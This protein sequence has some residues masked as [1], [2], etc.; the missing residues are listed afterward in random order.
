MSPSDDLEWN[1]ACK[2]WKNQAPVA[3]GFETQSCVNVV[4]V[5]PMIL[6]FLS[7]I[8]PMCI[9]IVMK[10]YISRMKCNISPAWLSRSFS[11]FIGKTEEQSGN[12]GPYLFRRLQ[13]WWNNSKASLQNYKSY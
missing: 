9:G 11:K 2:V 8:F 6:F 10:S 12:S 5:N 13:A 1:E 3:Q 7:C 4:N